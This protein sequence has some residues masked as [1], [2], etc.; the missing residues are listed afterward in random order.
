MQIRHAGMVSA[1]ALVLVT[2]AAGQAAADVLYED[3]FYWVP[4]KGDASVVVMNPSAP[5]VDALVKIQ[6]TVYDY[7]QGASH[8]AMLAMI[9]AINGDTVPTQP[10]D[11]YVYSITNLTYNPAPPQGEMGHGVA[12]YGVAIAP[13]LTLGVWAPNYA[14]HPWT[15]VQGVRWD[16]NMDGDATVGDG[17][18]ILQSQ[19]FGSFMVAVPAGT[20]HSV[21]VPAAVWTWTGEEPVGYTFGYVSGLVSGPVPEPAT[22]GLLGLGL[23]GLLKRRRN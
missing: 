8:L 22:F 18:G 15:G 6:E 9:G 5:P 4:G 13:A 19:T 12:G 21:T 14:N 10:F 20:P 2:L 23:A 16:I 1:M 3:I 17:W 7:A 11:L